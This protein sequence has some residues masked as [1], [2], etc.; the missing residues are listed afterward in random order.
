VWRGESDALLDRYVRQ[1]RSATAEQVQAMSD[2]QQAAAGGARPPRCSAST[3]SDLVP[4][5][6]DSDRARQYLLDSSMNLG[7]RR[8]LQVS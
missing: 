3:W 6:R 7:L 4:L 8:S 5:A 1:R 2:P